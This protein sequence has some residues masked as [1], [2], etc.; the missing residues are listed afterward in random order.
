LKN[1]G[2]CYLESIPKPG[3]ASYRKRKS[4]VLGQTLSHTQDPRLLSWRTEKIEGREG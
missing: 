1:Q 2:A 4:C 3:N